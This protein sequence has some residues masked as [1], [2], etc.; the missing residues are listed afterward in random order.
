MLIRHIINKLVC[1]IIYV[2]LYYGFIYSVYC[3]G[4]ILAEVF[5]NKINMIGILCV[6]IFGCIMIGILVWIFV[7]FFVR[8]NIKL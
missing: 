6:R 8:H 2:A 5:F 7:D 4:K 3:C 1:N